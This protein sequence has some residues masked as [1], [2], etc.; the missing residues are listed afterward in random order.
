MNGQIEGSIRGSNITSDSRV[1]AKC[2]QTSVF[3]L[4]PCF[5]A[6]VSCWLTL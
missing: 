3:G 6:P 4:E 1:A 2:L 5:L